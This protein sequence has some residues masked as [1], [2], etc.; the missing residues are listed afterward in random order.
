MQDP[1]VTSTDMNFN[2][3]IRDIANQRVVKRGG[4]LNKIRFIHWSNYLNLQVIRRKISRFPPG[5]ISLIPASRWLF[6]NYHMLYQSFKMFQA[7]NSPAA[8]GR[9]P[10]IREGPMKG[11]PRI[12]L[13]AREMIAS[14]NRHLNVETAI[15][16]VKEYQS[17]HLLRNEEI[18]LLSDMIVFCLLEKIID[19][20][21]KIIP[22]IKNKAKA[23]RVI[24]KI[25]PHFVIGN[26]RAFV[27]LKQLVQ[28]NDLRDHTFS[29][30][31]IYRL[32]SL[33]LNQQDILEFFN[34]ILGN[35]KDIDNN[36]LVRITE[37][38]RL[39]EAES[40]SAISS[41]I[42]SLDD[43]SGMEKDQFISSIS[44]VEQTLAK[45]PSKVYLHMDNNT[46]ARY[47]KAVEMLASRYRVSEIEIAKL[48]VTFAISPP[49]SSSLPAPK[50]VGTYLVGEGL[51]Y[52]KS[53]LSGKLLRIKDFFY[54][55]K[56]IRQILYFVGILA[57][58]AGI[59]P[60]LILLIEP[61][62]ASSYIGIILFL[63]SAFIPATAIAVS[64]MNSIYTKFIKPKAP[65]SMNF[66]REIPEN[67]KT[68]IVMPVILSTP[69]AVS[70]CVANLEQHYLVNRKENLYFAL[71]VDFKDA[72]EKSSPE[73][74]DIIQQTADQI[75]ELNRRHP[76]SPVLFSFFY[77]E[78][79][80]NA[81]QNCWMGWERK[82][83]KL[84]D[85]NSL[86]LGEQETGFLMPIG[87]A[88]IFPG[89]KYI[90]TLDSDTEL[91]NGSASEMIAVMEHPLNQP[92]LDSSER[93]IR[94]G[95]VII[96]SEVRNRAPSASSGICQRFF[97]SDSGFD[98]YATIVSDVYQ[99]T[100]D[101]GIY[102][103][104]GIYHLNAFHTLLHKK[105]PENCVLSH[106]LLEASYTRCGFASG[107]KL[108]NPVPSSVISYVKREHRWVRGDW[109]L[110][111]FIFRR[112]HLSFLSRWKMMDNLR[113]SLVPVAKI[114]LIITSILLIPAA[115]WIWLP[116]I[117]Y[118]PA[119]QILGVLAGVLFRKI[120]HPLNRIA[121]PVL[122]SNLSGIIMESVFFII[123]LPCRSYLTL[124]A[125]IRTLYRLVI[126]RR[127][128]L[129]WQT[130]ESIER[131]SSNNFS[132]Y[133][134]LMVPSF[135]VAAILIL[136]IALPLGLDLYMKI[137]FLFFAGLWIFSPAITY[138]ASKPP[139]P[140]KAEVLTDDEKS[141]LRIDA[142]K[143]WSYFVDFS[144]EDHHWLCPDHHQESPGPKTEHKVSPTNI[145]LQLLSALSARDLG[146]IGLFS[147][148]EICE[149]VLFTVDR[150]PKWYGHLYNWYD[151]R[152]LQILEPMY[153]STVDSGNFLAHLLTLKVA[154]QEMIKAP[155]FNESL[156]EGLDSL[157]KVDKQDSET[158]ALKIIGTSSQEQ[159]NQFPYHA[160][161]LKKLKKK[162]AKTAKT[163]SQAQPA[164]AGE[165]ETSNYKINNLYENINTLISDPNT[166]NRTMGFCFDL[167]QDKDLLSISGLENLLESP[168]SLSE[169]GQANAASLITRIEILADKIDYIVKQADFRPLYDYKK[170]LFRIGYHESNKKPD[171]GHYNLMASEA[172]LSSFL[173]I[174]KGDVPKK[175]WV[176]LGKPLTLFNGLPALVSWSGSMFEYLMPNLVM[177]TSEN[178]IMDYSNKASV[179]SQIVYA[180]KMHLP[181][182]ISESQYHVFDNLSNYQY[183][184]F[185]VAR[186]RLQ[187]SMSPVK[188]IAPY[189]TY[190][191]L[192]VDPK[193][194]VRNIEIMKEVG[195]AGIYGLYESLD[196]NNP[197]TSG[198]TYFFLI[199]TFMTHHLG[200]SISA[201]NNVLNKNILQDRFHAEPM[202]RANESI[203]EDKF[204]SNLITIASKGY[205]I[206]IDIKE[207][208][209][210]VMESRNFTGVHTPYPVAHV[211]SNGRYQL[212]LTT[213]GNGFSSCD[214]IMLNRWRPNF[215]DGG[216]G[217]F[218]YL[219]NTDTNLLWS[220][221]YNPT[222]VMPDSYNVIFSHDKAEY[223]RM[224][225][226]ISTYTEIT[227]SPIDQ[228]EI[229]RVTLT[230]FKDKPV[231]IELTSYMEISDNDYMADV[232]HP[233]YSKLFIETLYDANR[234]F[235]A[236][237]RRT[238]KP[239]EKKG[240]IMHLIRSDERISSPVHF[241]IDRQA[242]IGRG[243]SLTN[244][245]TLN[246]H[247]P[248]SEKGG[249]STDPILSLQTT[250]NI[251]PG[252]S[253]SVIFITAYCSSLNEVNRL[254]EKYAV[255]FTDED[256]FKMSLTSSL[257]E[258][259]YLKITSSQLNAIQDLVGS[260]YYPSNY[261]KEVSEPLNENTLGKSGLYRF[262]L[263]EVQPIMLLKISEIGDLEI[264]K[265]ILFVYEY[266]RIQR[267]KI[268]LVILNEQ[269]DSY[270]NRLQQL[271]F[272][273]TAT[274]HVCDEGSC[275]YGIFVLKS[276]QISAEER[277]MLLTVARVVFTTQTGIYFSKAK[278]IW[279]EEEKKDVI[280]LPAGFNPAVD[281][282]D[283]ISYHNDTVPEFFN[284]IGGFVSDGKE[285]E[286]RLD[287]GTKT[288]A[289]WINVIANEQFGFQISET[290]AGYTWSD[291][292]RENKLTIWSNDPVQDP[293]SE[294]VYIKV[295]KTGAI[296]SPFAMYSG[297]KGP[298]KVNH[299]FGYSIFEK[300]DPKLRQ[301]L[302]VFA[303]EKQP[304][305]LMILSLDNQ[306]DESYDLTVTYFAEWVLG[307]F[308]ELTERF[309]STEFDEANQIFSAKIF[310]TD[311]FKEKRAFLFSSEPIASFTGDMKTFIGKDGSV[312]YPK[313][314]S[315]QKLSNAS[316]YGY[317][318]CGA[319]QCAVHVDP[320]SSREIVFGLGCASSKEQMVSL[321]SSLRS[322]DDA[323]IELAD[324]MRFW[325]RLPGDVIVKTPDRA[326]DIMMNGWLTYQVLVCRYRA[327]AAF[328]QCGGAFG[329][330]DQLQDVLSLVAFD[331]SITR[332]HI[333]RCCSRQFIEGD[334][335]HW[336]HEP[337]GVGIR[338]RIS[339]NLLWLPYVASR[340]CTQTGD[341]SLMNE[342]ATFLEE[343]ALQKNQQEIL[344]KPAV[345][346][347][348]AK[349]YSHC[350]LAIDYAS[351]FG[352][353]GLPLIKGGDWNDGMNLVGPE[354]IGESV[355]LGWFLLTILKNFIP[356]CQK[357]GDKNRAEKYQK[358]A[359]A[360]VENIE[361]SAWDGEWYL[362][363][364]YDNGQTMG[365]AKNE[366]CRIDSISQSWAVLSGGAE[367]TRA[368]IAL[369]SARKYLVK[370]EDGI[371]LL[372]TPPFDKSRNNPGYIKGYNPGIRENGG[373]YTHAAVWL[374]MA[375]CE[376]SDSNEAYRI[377]NMINPIQSTSGFQSVS[378]YEKEPYV[379]S[380]DVSYG[381]PNTGRG[382]W[383]WYTGAAGW[384]YN[385]ILQNFLGIRREGDTL[386]FSPC[387]P[388]NFR[389]YQV[390]Y[391]FGQ[392]LYEINVLNYS[393][394]G[395]VV[396]SVSIDGAKLES[397][398]VGLIDDGKVHNVEINLSD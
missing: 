257:L 115:K 212:L 390:E 93:Q 307:T 261:F 150:L 246:S 373:Q 295:N 118:E 337:D 190:L 205:S 195:A 55:L 160:S 180:R 166:G 208:S 273:H 230:N 391:K 343:N 263:N 39:F 113:R 229:R 31:L 367:N 266:L 182:G 318:P 35:G 193:S 27:D 342:Q 146:F 200:M 285:Y 336:W 379:M 210:G 250:I 227:I 101:E 111:P 217:T 132:S 306:T 173:A 189:A 98:P 385:T 133:V 11:Y 73:D 171:H 130:A 277:L 371:V 319:I 13:I 30:H 32:N 158:E 222:I 370:P 368:L 309:I 156:I 395:C 328:Y 121:F 323:K 377:L 245:E 122:W 82:R 41:Y 291:N 26:R 293:V 131:N 46:R 18:N 22:A 235:L 300:R 176:A 194:A 386:V 138:F 351:R 241:E 37:R 329:F 109:Q 136:C 288:P 91:T 4:I 224:D 298:F 265:D 191:A 162:S 53:S 203:L 148:V 213:Q 19:E 68:F 382:G 356:I 218:I 197:D 10:V 103:G 243:G 232:S 283:E 270:D 199:R 49:V 275:R 327:K 110:M 66:E 267:V 396:G 333:L 186:M 77:R 154:L 125:I 79:E 354:E 352:P 231:N 290:G 242:F 81:N 159:A 192:S 394:N 287:K 330:R 365:S 96:Q 384:M 223:R 175:H 335:Q 207:L 188:V 2:N 305:K 311:D 78:R 1:Y 286:I 172:R 308:R 196:F 339:D 161:Q 75:A 294:M 338:S 331:P 124:D 317:E 247:L 363:A 380:G 104:K 284:G 202:I 177:R 29:S 123:L 76:H 346:V 388:P 325:S 97:S 85:F 350:V 297:A 355:W 51:A 349:V 90:I 397:K 304:V 348:T 253:T 344:S 142:V 233:A 378:H 168:S 83:G 129:E 87:D 70:G 52:L 126:S 88:T 268:D 364:Y 187:S 387:I 165:K 153:I 145:G 157:Q 280:L 54:R 219:R 312:R 38:E 167:I 279:P 225:G 16:M 347:L 326:M 12:Y 119:T 58:T 296:T 234:K 255:R 278:N 238:T 256:I 315:G 249:P 5:M 60:L 324:V 128:L 169:K 321:A 143:I 178:S 251:L 117:L 183:G 24:K 108:M 8:F 114:L 334:V 375:F 358:L 50:H 211:L 209:K 144:D 127:N 320:H 258:I 254:S 366:E 374:A 135:I 345:S 89:I 59:Y 359:D 262:G 260:L 204:K 86:I 34:D 152:T 357:Q 42:S 372:L 140:E 69:G 237:S 314:I 33:S 220:N 95:Y 341:W 72:K 71:L 221:T 236:A 303:A 23:E 361:K 56:I 137:I 264:L 353:H 201:I 163:A 36:L 274:L 28:K 92:V 198:T 94:S 302:T 215:N 184:P 74:S 269:E 80:W 6:D 147:F 47:R 272:E 174:A 369:N 271:I 244:P 376:M 381:F 292:S 43:M 313:E 252:R 105:I 45:D 179:I 322:V 299:G 310:F 120:R 301:T 383:S 332:S 362:R 141:E 61:R 289:P 185:G 181:W 21:K 20:A 340:Y 206:D 15:R 139:D 393:G 360:L 25:I 7:S 170:Q 44:I 398:K 14:S 9:L 248:F 65:F 316:G 282:F 107:I 84:E 392:S 389:R 57:I 3:R 276:N 259:E 214:D 240:Y 67:C 228:L 149:R 239:A 17:I 100:F 116:F 64:T 62:K 226:Q 63:I 164:Y 216:S 134:R 155:V 102:A 106:D 281:V 112:S 40:E 151:T 48:A 99:D